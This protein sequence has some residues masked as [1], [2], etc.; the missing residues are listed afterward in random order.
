MT[1]KAG[2]GHASH[3]DAHLSRVRRAQQLLDNLFRGLPLGKRV[4]AGM[5]MAFKTTLSA[6]FAYAVGYLLNP[7]EPYW[8]A[9]SAVAVTQPHYGDTR[10]ASRDRVL[11]TIFGAL[12]GVLGLWV[13][14]TGDLMSFAVA[15]ALVTVACWTANA[16]AAARI[17]GITAAILLL[18]PAHGPIWEVAA[19]RLVQVISG[20]ACALAVGWLVSRLEERAERKEEEQA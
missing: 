8:A 7:G 14:G 11:G 9:I 10:G 19:W 16:G 3:E 12:A 2:P 1:E 18:V 4:R 17:G 20:N 6:V 5:F 15:L 13:G